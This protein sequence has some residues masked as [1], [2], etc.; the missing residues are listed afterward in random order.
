VKSRIGRGGC[1][2]HDS[3]ALA[4]LIDPQV[5]TTR[6]ASVDIELRGLL[7]RGCTVAW[8]PADEETLVAGLQLSDIRP[9]QIAQDVDNDRFMPLLLERLSA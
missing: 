4:A 8:N 6:E 2:L 3:L 9:V 1:A 5:I 7:T